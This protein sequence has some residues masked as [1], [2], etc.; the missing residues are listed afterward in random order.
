MQSD[1]LSGPHQTDYISAAAMGSLAKA[2]WV[3]LRMR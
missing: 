2:R 1:L 3:A